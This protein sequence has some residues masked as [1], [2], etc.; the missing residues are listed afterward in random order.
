MSLTAL[1]RKIARG[2]HGIVHEADAARDVR[3]EV[4]H[5]LDETAAALVA[6]G[7]TPSAARRAARLHLGTPASIREEVRASLWESTVTSL[8]TDVRYAAR[9]LRRSP[10]FTVVVVLVISLGVGAVTTIFSAA[11]AFLFK[12]LPGA[13]D[14]TRLVGID[15]IESRGDG[16]TQAS[17]P[18]YV[19]L[20][21]RNRTLSGVAAWSKTDLTITSG[22]TG[23]AAYG[24]LVSGNFFSVLGVRPA[25][26]RFFLP[27][28]DA[29]PLTHPVIVVSH[30]FWRSELGG[31]SSAV[32]RTVGVNGTAFTLI[33]VAPPEFRG[34][35]TPIVTSAWVPLM[36]QPRIRPNRS[37]DAAAS[38][39]L[40]TFGRLKDGMSRETARQDLIALTRARITEG[41]EPEWMRNNDSIRLISLTGLPDDA[42]KAMLA[43]TGM[44]LGVALL[45]LVIA[46]VNVG[47]MLSA[48]AVARRHEMAIRVAL[49]AARG[50]LVRQLLT[51]SLVLFALG[52]IGGLS[53]ATV[54]TGLLER[55]PLPLSVPLSLELSPDVRV[56]AFALLLSL[57]TGL[58]FG[59]TPAL[60]ASNPDIAGRLR[61][62]A[63]TGDGR[64]GIVSDALVVGQLALSLVLVV[65]AGLLLRALERGSSVDPQFDVTGVATASLKSESWGYD[66]PKARAF[67]RTLRERIEAIPGVTHVSYTSGLP[68]QW[69]N[70][71]TDIRLDDAPPASASDS[72]GT[73]VRV[74][75]VDVDY[76]DVLRI[77]IVDGREFVRTD[78]ETAPR[79]AIVNETLARKHWPGG[80][81]IGHTFLSNDQRVTI[82]GVARDAKYATLTE[83]TPEMAYFALA[84]EWQAEQVLMVRTTQGAEALAP[85]IQG[86]VASLDPSVPR[87]TVISLQRATQFVLLPQRV[88]AFVAGALGVLGLVLAT[89]GLYGIIAY[90]VSRRS[91]EIGVRMA[92]GARA[93]D[94]QRMVV[95]S[96]MRLAGLGVVIGLLLA[97]G[98]SRLL[99]AFLYGVNPLDAPTFVATSLL[100]VAVALM[101][102]YLPA[103]RAAMADP[104]IA[105]R[106]D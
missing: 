16:G 3:D 21:D 19:L 5:Y 54:S 26:G 7:M 4:E 95:L 86:A 59:V 90:S 29:T 50:R 105:L 75:Q 98:A 13:N 81:A 80:S 6:Q 25:I 61:N 11:N 10:I 103:R 82:V 2:T 102:S 57:V 40:W 17:Y 76:F 12:P 97:A 48:R 33:G 99:V 35:F 84:Q 14:A 28:E 69:D 56:L 23:H 87:P 64:R 38:S 31:D 53:L 78:D 24:N 71:N 37:L 22:G 49:G 66:E 42:R 89:V 39:W 47:A 41:V 36:M 92:L 96:G 72:R 94:V 30:A 88:A 44:L 106:A 63:R 20:R 104:L 15:R 18:Y 62:D 51:E 60:R 43:F 83:S 8:V 9:M 101:A 65:S 52:A 55:I 68:L 34:V 70:S 73:R 85:A 100:F 1:W 58:V 77:P 46:S 93:V 79:V 27:E 67:S 91:R 74:N 45:V 32:G